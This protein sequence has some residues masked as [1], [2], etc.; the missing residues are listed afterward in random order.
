MSTRLQHLRL[1]E[2][3]FAL[4]GKDLLELNLKI[5]RAIKMRQG[6]EVVYN[7]ALQRNALNADI[8]FIE[9]QMDNLRNKKCYLGE[10]VIERNEKGD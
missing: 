3:K 10:V 2:E 5:E 1:L 7:L 6:S 9:K 8:H 4:K